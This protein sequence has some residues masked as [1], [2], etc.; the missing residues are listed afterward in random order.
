M[1]SSFQFS[2][3]PQNTDLPRNRGKD[4]SVTMFPF[5]KLFLVIDAFFLSATGFFTLIWPSVWWRWCTSSDGLDLIRNSAP[6][7]QEVKDSRQENSQQELVSGVPVV[8]GYH[9]FHE[10]IGHINHK[11][12]LHF[13]R[14][15]FA[16]SVFSLGAGCGF[17]AF[18]PHDQ[19]VKFAC[20]MWVFHSIVTGN[21]IEQY[22]LNGKGFFT[23]R[24]AVIGSIWHFVFWLGYMVAIILDFTE[25]PNDAALRGS[26]DDAGEVRTQLY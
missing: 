17:A 20:V 2:V 1:T 16:A 3:P 14:V 21:Y 15:Q 19:M 26:F 6:T 12:Y 22:R 11:P 10:Y 23:H 25:Y 13:F 24:G 8:T 9:E 18:M 4:S 7:S 5:A